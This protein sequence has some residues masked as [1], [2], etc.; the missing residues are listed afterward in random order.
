M[1]AEEEEVRTYSELVVRIRVKLLSEMERWVGSFRDAIT[2]LRVPGRPVERKA[3]RFRGVVGAVD[4]GSMVIPFA[5]RLVGVAS[6]LAVRAGDTSMR[7]GS[8]SPG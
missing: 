6:A 5:D 4:G 2:G 3:A 1:G 8:W 7:G